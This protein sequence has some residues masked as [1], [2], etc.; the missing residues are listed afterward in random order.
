MRFFTAA[1]L[2]S[3]IVCAADAAKPGIPETAFKLLMLMFVMAACMTLMMLV[4][5]KKK[6]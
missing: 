2:L 1:L 5:L 3:G 6:G 4:S